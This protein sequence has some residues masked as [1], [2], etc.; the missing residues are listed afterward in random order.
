MST[1]YSQSASSALTGS[2]PAETVSVATYHLGLKTSAPISERTRL[3]YGLEWTRHELELSNPS[4]LPHTLKTLSAPLGFANR[5]DEHWQFL[6]MASPLLA[7]ADGGIASAGFDVPVMALANYVVSP[8]LTWSFGLR[9]GPHSD[10]KLL[11]IAGV[12]WKF[13]PDWKLVFGWPESGL[14]YRAT[15]RLTLRAVATIQGGDYRLATDPRPATS[16]AG[17]SL[18]KS[19]LEYREIRVGIAAEYAFTPMYSLRADFGQVVDQRFEYLSRGV[20]M[21]GSHP[22]YFALSAL[23]RF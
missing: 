14:S 2:G 5:L 20:K 9:Y 4:W 10:I 22:S 8:E 19:W 16:R 6:A 13:A 15:E 1:R 18:D 11:P 7:G 3:F 21:K 17:A 12:T 23:G